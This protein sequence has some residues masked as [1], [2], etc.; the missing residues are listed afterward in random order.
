[1]QYV[2]FEAIFLVNYSKAHYSFPSSSGQYHSLI[3]PNPLGYVENHIEIGGFGT[4]RVNLSQLPG[5]YT[6]CVA[7]S[8]FSPKK[9]DL[10]EHKQSLIRVSEYNSSFQSN[11]Q[12]IFMA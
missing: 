4:V 12:D 7:M 5:E 3:N 2:L 8:T 10:I 11:K 1:M 9:T 6:P